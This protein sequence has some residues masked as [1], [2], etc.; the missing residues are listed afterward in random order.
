L[1]EGTLPALRVGK[2]LGIPVIGFLTDMPEFADECDEHSKLKSFLYQRYNTQCQRALVKFD[3]YIFLTAAMSE[4]LNVQNKP[5]LLMECL[6]NAA[7][8]QPNSTEKPSEKPHVMYAGKLHKQFGLDI[9]MDAI[10]LVQTPCVFDFYGDGN[11]LPEIKK[12]ALTNSDICV[13]GIVPVSTVMEAERNST[14]L[15]NPRPSVGAFTKYS[16]PSKTAEYMLSGTPVLMFKL[17]GIPDE[18]DEYLWYSSE[19]T[20][21]ALATEIDRLLQ[22]PNEE[23]VAQGSRAK[24]FIL[25]KSNVNQAERFLAFCNGE[26]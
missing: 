14:L 7:D 23:L 9:L 13:H 19:E 11:Y 12:Q 16:F 1:L 26:M 6:V 21:R 22:L 10:S 8:V 24:T 4:S 17:P 5:W 15:I 20:P 3:G 2:K 18:Y 25:K